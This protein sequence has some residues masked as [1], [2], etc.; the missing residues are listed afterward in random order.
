MSNE[1]REVVNESWLEG[2]IGCCLEAR[3]D[4][5]Q[6]RDQWPQIEYIDQDGVTRTH[7]FDWHI[8]LVNKQRFAVAVKPFDKVV[9]TGLAQ[10]IELIRKQRSHRDHANGIVILT[11]RDFT[12]D[13]AANAKA[14]LR[15]RRLRDDR[16]VQAALTELKT[17]NGTVLFGDL[18]RHAPVEAY[19]RNALWT[20]IDLGILLPLVREKI[21]DRTKM[22]VNQ[23]ALKD[24]FS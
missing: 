12:R 8:T 11:E 24:G 21:T 15:A 20:L 2:G 18:V 19:R 23:D 6:L 16:E 22:W 10:V 3:R 7:T 1:N 5:V 9:S 4:V 17:V 14:V 13:D